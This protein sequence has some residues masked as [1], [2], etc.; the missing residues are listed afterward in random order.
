MVLN[1]SY[2]VE[3]HIIKSGSNIKI[4]E[5][6]VNDKYN[7]MLSDK[8]NEPIQTSDFLKMCEPLIKDL[9]K[10]NLISA[11]NVIGVKNDLIEYCSREWA[12]YKELPSLA[13]LK[14]YLV[15][16]DQSFATGA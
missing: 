14:L 1:K 8:N 10:D 13:K 15:N 9:E 16:R 3:G 11:N 12:R 5:M 4:L 7:D 6:E 2:I